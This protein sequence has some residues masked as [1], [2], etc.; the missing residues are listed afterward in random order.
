MSQNAEIF[1]GMIAK[2]MWLRSRVLLGC[3]VIFLLLILIYV[4]NEQRKECLKHIQQ[5]KEVTVSH[6]R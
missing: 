5:K 1:I 6:D 2:Y 3:T 4:V